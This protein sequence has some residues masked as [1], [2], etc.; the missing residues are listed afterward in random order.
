[1]FILSSWTNLQLKFSPFFK[2]VKLVTELL[3]ADSLI[4][5]T[6]DLDRSWV[7]ELLLSATLLVPLNK[8]GFDKWDFDDAWRE[9]LEFVDWSDETDEVLLDAT[10]DDARGPGLLGLVFPGSLKAISFLTALGLSA[11]K[12]E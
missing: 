12:M 5:V 2:D 7:F 3:S 1:M 9:E 11:P 4:A 10:F 6:S 8:W